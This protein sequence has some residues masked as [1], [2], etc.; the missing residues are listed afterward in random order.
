MEGWSVA[1]TCLRLPCAHFSHTLP[2]VSYRAIR[3]VH[4][5]HLATALHP[6]EM[7]NRLVWK[8]LADDSIL[9]VGV[10][11]D[12]ASKPQFG[13]A[14]SA[15]RASGG[16]G[17]RSAGVNVGSS[18]KKVEPVGGA[19]APPRKQP[20]KSGFQPMVSGG[21]LGTMRISRLSMG[22]MSDKLG[23]TYRVRANVRAC[24]QR[25]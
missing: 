12:H 17:R 8:K 25:R 14:L 11:T 7:V 23:T 1:H 21:A 20:G 3:N 15:S 13:A 2:Q 6:R 19:A 16:G 22:S 18:A 9:L 24:E 5:H 10:P 4:H